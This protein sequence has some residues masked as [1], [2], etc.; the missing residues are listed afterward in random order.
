[1]LQKKNTE[2]I[3]EIQL[4]KKNG[5]YIYEL[6]LLLSLL[7]SF[8]HFWTKRFMNWLWVG[9]TWVHHSIPA[10]ICRNSK[11]SLS[12]KAN[13][14]PVLLDI[15]IRYIGLIMRTYYWDAFFCFFM[16]ADLYMVLVTLSTN[17]CHH[18]VIPWCCFLPATCWA[19]TIQW[20]SVSLWSFFKGK[21]FLFFL[22][23]KVPVECCAFFWKLFSC[24][25][26]W[27]LRLLRLFVSSWRLICLL[28]FFHF[29]RC[30]FKINPDKGTKADR[31]QSK[32]QYIL[33]YYKNN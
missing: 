13:K 27:Y 3:G 2:I 15:S 5:K 12:R 26:F 29:S 17:I 32:K 1:M 10:N 4:L 18:L 28:Y 8:S 23:Q 31:K 7:F 14:T 22:F 19:S 6:L 16:T 30:I 21:F 20:K 25:L 33:S 11:L 9:L 24:L